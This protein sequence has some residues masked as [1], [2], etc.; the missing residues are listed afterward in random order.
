MSDWSWFEGAAGA[1][2]RLTIALE[3][4]E[5]NRFDAHEK[6]SGA[7]RFLASAQTNV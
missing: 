3:A 7:G 4:L 6:K 1:V 2:G 5:M